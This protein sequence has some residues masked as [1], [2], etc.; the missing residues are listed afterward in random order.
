MPVSKKEKKIVENKSHEMKCYLDDTD[1][2]GVCYYANYLKWMERARAEILTTEFL[3]KMRRQDERGRSA[4][5]E[6]SLNF[7]SGARFGDRIR[8]T[9][10]TEFQSKFRVLFHHVVYRVCTTGETTRLEELVSG[11]IS[12]C[13]DNGGGRFTLPF[14]VRFKKKYWK[15]SYD[16]H[17]FNKE[18][19]Y[20]LTL[21]FNKNPPAKKVHPKKKVL[22][23]S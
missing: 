6:A 19:L 11:K 9:T 4:I 1:F 14:R 2:T 21:K 16:N 20:F 23:R 15:M 12:I 3:S 5:H 7:K 17:Y 22:N 13:L 8:I 18:T 10:R